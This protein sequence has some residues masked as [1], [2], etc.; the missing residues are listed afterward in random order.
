MA[1]EGLPVPVS[2]PEP[3][4]HYLDTII[5]RGIDRTDAASID[6]V[7]ED[8][9]YAVVLDVVDQETTRVETRPLA[10]GLV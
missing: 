4:P 5:E 9:G 7:A 3:P 6:D 10:V 2:N 1:A 8:G